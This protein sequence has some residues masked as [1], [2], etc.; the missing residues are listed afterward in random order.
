MRSIVA[1]LIFL[2]MVGGSAEA[3]TADHDRR[4]LVEVLHSE[5][6]PGPIFFHTVRATLLVTAARGLPT[7]ATVYKVIPWQVPPPRQGH[8]AWMRCTQIAV[9]GLF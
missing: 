6:L 9:S 5:E 8:K 2:P 7:E 4:C 3:G 1:A